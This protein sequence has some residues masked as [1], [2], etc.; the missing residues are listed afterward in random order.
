[1]PFTNYPF[2]VG[3]P[4]DSSVLFSELYAIFSTANYILWLG[5]VIEQ[6]IFFK[7]GNLII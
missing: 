6:G 3:L 5:F 1:M 4:D 2:G 7:H